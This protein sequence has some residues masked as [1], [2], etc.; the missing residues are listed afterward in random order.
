M[1]YYIKKKWYLLLFFLIS[2]S[3][4]LPLES[5]GFSNYITYIINEYSK[6]KTNLSLIYYYILI[7]IVIL[8]FTK[9]VATIELHLE[10]RIDRE[11]MELIRNEMFRSIIEKYQ[12]KYSEIEIGKLIS[13]FSIIPI[14]YQ[15]LIYR[16][17]KELFP[18]ALSMFILNIYFYFINIKLGFTISLFFFLNI[19]V[20]LYNKKKSQEL[21]IEKLDKQISLNE[22]ISDKMSNILSILVNG[23][24]NK[25]IN[26]NA[27]REK[28]YKKCVKKS[29]IQNTKVE[30]YLNILNTIFFILMLLIYNYEIRSN[31]TKNYTIIASMF[32]FIYLFSFLNNSTWYINNYFNLVGTIKHFDLEFIN[33]GKKINVN[34]KENIILKTGCIEFKNV[35]FNYTTKKIINNLNFKIMDKKINCIIGT[36]GSGKTTII[37]LILGLL[38]LTTGSITIDNRNIDTFPQFYLN[39]NISMVSQNI[40]LFNGTILENIRYGNQNTPNITNDK[41]NSFIRNLNLQNTVF[42]KLPD[43]LQ[44]KVG[45]NGS[46]LSN[47]QQQIALILRAFLQNKKI[48]ILDEPTTALDSNTKKI[49]LDLIKKLSHNKTIIIVTHDI[50]VKN[51]SHNFIN[52]NEINK[53]SY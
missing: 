43:G 10:Y 30:L 44:T 53:I 31:K 7:I 27:Y 16:F 48:I 51:I 52:L 21:T 2:A 41:I 9:I 39:S 38:P 46:Y 37:K 19:L 15:N 13:Q 6:E 3:V 34:Y 35:N 45:V 4:V 26:E 29:N 20:I 11:L 5:I 24:M 18:K 25:E 33:K 1:K 14:Q 17:M 8:I 23:N 49:I 47:G 42:K 28:N 22:K 50:D 40:K 36:S 32:I 12:K